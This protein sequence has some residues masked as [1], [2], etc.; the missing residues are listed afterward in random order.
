MR[1]QPTCDRRDQA[2][3]V[4]RPGVHRR[5]CE[6]SKGRSAAMERD[7]LIPQRHGF[8]TRTPGRDGDPV[9]AGTF[10]V[11][12]D[13]GEL[14]TEKRLWLFDIN[15]DASGWPVMVKDDAVQRDIVTRTRSVANSLVG[16]RMGAQVTMLVV[17]AR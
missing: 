10:T 16:A 14:P 4:A 8:S 2:N 9:I 1:N 17:A 5:M 6:P 3:A 7:Q 15:P 11:S 12:G 13:S